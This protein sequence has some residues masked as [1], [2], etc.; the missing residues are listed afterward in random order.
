MKNL[1]L[2]IKIVIIV[3]VS[4]IICSC[5]N[6]KIPIPSKPLIIIEI[7]SIEQKVST[8]AYKYKLIDKNGYVFYLTESS[9]FSEPPKRM[10]GDSI[11]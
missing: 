10:I 4:I 3:Y 8:Y 5:N 2:L 11:K 1:K 6:R 9:G 7:T